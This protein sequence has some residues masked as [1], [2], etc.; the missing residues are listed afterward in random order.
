MLIRLLCRASVSVCVL[1]LSESVHPWT[2]S[3]TGLSPWDYASWRVKDRLP[4]S[5][6]PAL[7]YWRQG[8]LLKLLEMRGDGEVSVDKMIETL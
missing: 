8:L 4:K 6:V 5:Q 1:L 7:D 3:L 2:P